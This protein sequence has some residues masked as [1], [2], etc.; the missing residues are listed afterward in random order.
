V[1]RVL[2]M[3][4]KRSTERTVRAKAG[5]RAKPR[6]GRSKPRA[7]GGTTG[8]RPIWRGQLAFGLVQIPIELFPAVARNELNF[9]LLDRRDLEPVGYLKVNKTTGEEVPSEEI[10][11]G[12]EVSRGR[13]VV[14]SD[15]EIEAAAGEASRT[16]EIVEFVERDD[17][18]AP[19]FE[20]PLFL[21]PGEG[22]EKV[23]ALLAR[24]LGESGR[25]GLGKIVL[26]TRESL[27]A[28]LARDGRLILE[29]LRWPH[30]L[31]PEPRLP[32]AARLPAKGGGREL[33]MA[34]RLID[35]MSGKFKPAE[36][37]DRF[38]KELLA[39]VRRRARTGSPPPEEKPR[40]RPAR[41]TNVV[42]LVSLLEKSVQARQQGAKAGAR[43]KRSA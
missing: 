10:V 7:H 4:P 23:Y 5:A 41:A 6:A 2:P 28:L 9:D 16:L 24:A 26:R 38:Q 19:Y 31:R 20:R 33:E 25:I 35:E 39:L 30:E 42:D 40:R 11:R 22:G 29:L 12:V 36:F 43:R 21:L 13:H 32:E 18:A 14:V 8:G 1:A 17:L 3:R 27:A 37:T 15:A 34:R